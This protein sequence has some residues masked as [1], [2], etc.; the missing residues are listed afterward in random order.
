MQLKRSLKP[1]WVV[2]IL[3]LM[4]FAWAILLPFDSFKQAARPLPARLPSDP[5]A[6]YALLQTILR[7]QPANGAIRLRLARV[8]AA[9]H[10]NPVAIASFEAVS[11][12]L[13]PED[14]FK[15]LSLYL[16]SQDLASARQT[17]R[18]LADLPNL[19]PAQFER[20]I[21]LQWQFEDWSGARYSAANWVLADPQNP[22][23]WRLSALAAVSFEPQIALDNITH[24]V[25]LGNLPTDIAF[26]T[27]LTEALA[28]TDPASRQLA[29]GRALG[30]QGEWRLA[31]QVFESATDQYPNIAEAWALLGQAQMELGQ[32]ALPALN[33]AAELD[34]ASP[35]VLLALSDYWLSQAQPQTALSYLEQAASA[36]P[37][38]GLWQVRIADALATQGDFNGA[39]EHYQLAVELEPENVSY[40]SELAVFSAVKGMNLETIGLSAARQALLLAPDNPATL[41]LMGWTLA[42][43]GENI[44]AET[45][46]R[47]ALEVNPDYAMAHLHL[48]Q[49]LITL[50]RFSE[51]RTELRIAIS[52]DGDGAIGQAAAELLSDYWK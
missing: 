47:R 48:A 16:E 33:R 19:L 41:D 23:A 4:M 25:S 38:Q 40:W 11:D 28:R 35:I 32:D 13:L 52:L 6:A 20:L 49:L 44:S 34:S 36:Y 39:L 37:E 50:Q 17:A 42:I 46:L 29:I 43:A 3:T 14:H 30:V 31:C 5:Q 27:A 21:R 24:S 26:Q 12:S 10:Q 9:L 51:A 2:L 18:K 8:E 22:A 1:G 7:A 15:L 45:F